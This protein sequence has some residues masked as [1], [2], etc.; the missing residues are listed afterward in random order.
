M[1]F[2]ESDGSGVDF[3][4]FYAGCPPDPVFHR[5]LDLVRGQRFPS[6]TAAVVSVADAGTRVVEVRSTATTAVV[7]VELGQDSGVFFTEKRRGGWMVE[8]GEGCAAWPAAEEIA[9]ASD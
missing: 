6:P 2:Y 9:G 8:G 7:S 5:N 1:L 3:D 4:A